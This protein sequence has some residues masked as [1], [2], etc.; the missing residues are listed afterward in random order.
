MQFERFGQLPAELRHKIGKLA[1]PSTFRIDVELRKS[2]SVMNCAF[3]V[4]RVTRSVLACREAKGVI[5]KEMENAE[6]FKGVCGEMRPA[7]STTTWKI[8]RAPDI[9][10]QPDHDTIYVKGFPSKVPFEVLS[11]AYP[12]LCQTT[13][14]IAV[15]TWNPLDAKHRLTEVPQQLCNFFPRPRAVTLVIITGIEK[16]TAALEE[17]REQLQ[18]DFASTS[19]F[20]DKFMRLRYAKSF[21]ELR[22]IPLYISSCQ[23]KDIT[24]PTLDKT[25][26]SDS[27]WFLRCKP[28]AEISAA[29]IP[30]QDR[31]MLSLSMRDQMF[32]Q[33]KAE[34][35]DDGHKQVH[36]G[37][38]PASCH[39]PPSAVSALPESSTLD[40]IPSSSSPENHNPPVSP[41]SITSLL[42]L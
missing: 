16:R 32:W 7:D 24:K 26:F 18:Q 25:E 40:D 3:T 5:E 27:F 10:L 14:A 23:W 15:S 13:I 28:E 6:T 11:F 17:A 1:A 33:V 29:N 8:T 2:G 21:A 36:M 4:T 19:I 39:K 30:L 20:H 34:R 35:L 9:R 22:N 42:I 12:A 38:F 41:S 37:A 31:T